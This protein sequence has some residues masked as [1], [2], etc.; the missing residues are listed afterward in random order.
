MHRKEQF[1][2]IE[3]LI[4]IAI[5]AILASMLLPAL[6]SARARAKSTHCA[7]NLKQQGLM[8][9]MY[10]DSYG[11]FPPHLNASSTLTWADL[12]LGGEGS[13]VARMKPFIDPALVTGATAQTSL[14]DNSAG[15]GISNTG[16]GYNFRYIGGSYGNGLPSPKDDQRSIKPSYIRAASQGYLVLDSVYGSTVMDRGR[17]RVTEFLSTSAG[18]GFP[19]AQRHARKINILYC[20]GHAG[21]TSVSL[22]MNPYLA[23]GNYNNIHWTAGRR[24][25]IVSDLFYQ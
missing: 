20:D 19:D 9:A 10:T 14:I 15:S 5:I 13:V 1:T 11:Y 17:Y 24:D 16:Y 4:V 21:S 25:A 12:L 2:L 3:L 7:G 22:I 8:F 23:I 6:N 18:S